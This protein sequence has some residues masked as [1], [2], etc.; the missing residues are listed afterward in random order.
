MVTLKRK[1]KTGATV[2][3]AILEQLR[4]RGLKATPAR[5]RI[6][7]LLQESHNV[8]TLEEIRETCGASQVDFATVYRT[9]VSFVEV[10]LA[11]SVELGDGQTRYESATSDHEDHHHH[12]IL[13]VRCRRIES[14]HLCAVEKLEK[15]VSRLGY[16]EITHRL[17]FSGVCKDCR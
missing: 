13:C 11:R 5:A 14:V 4:E 16:R 7:E 6:L 2:A 12:H 15:E 1:T 17:E 10:G 8:L 9:L 3:P